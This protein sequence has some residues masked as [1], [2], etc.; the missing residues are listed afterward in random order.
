[1]DEILEIPCIG[2]CKT[3]ASVR[4]VSDSGEGEKN[5]NNQRSLLISTDVSWQG[6]R[7]PALSAQPHAAHDLSD[8]S[9][10]KA[11]PPASMCSPRELGYGEWVN[12]G[13]R[14]ISEGCLVVSARVKMQTCVSPRL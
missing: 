2:Q 4:K 5:K 13:L 10:A 8:Q 7:L 1:M 12:Q 6:R 11:C 9:A 3:Y 14:T